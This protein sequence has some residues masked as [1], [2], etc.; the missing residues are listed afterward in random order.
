MGRFQQSLSGP[1][2]RLPSRHSRVTVVRF[3]QPQCPASAHVLTSRCTMRRVIGATSSTSG[4]AISHAMSQA[5]I[6]TFSRSAPGPDARMVEMPNTTRDI[7]PDRMRPNKAGAK[8][9]GS[10]TTPPQ[11]ARRCAPAHWQSS[12]QRPL[13]SARHPQRKF[14]RPKRSCRAAWRRWTWRSACAHQNAK[15]RIGRRRAQC[16]LATSGC[17]DAS[18]A[19]GSQQGCGQTGP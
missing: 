4:R 11:P 8:R 19:L 17:R 7:S 16:P 9:A 10:I 5:P 2:F 3:R 6:Q 13:P 18:L 14:A 1:V 12:G 15:R